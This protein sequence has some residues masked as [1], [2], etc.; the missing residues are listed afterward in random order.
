M[1]NQPGQGVRKEEVGKGG[2]GGRVGK[3]GKEREKGER[4]VKPEG[5]FLLC[6]ACRGGSRMGPW[7]GRREAETW[8]RNVCAERGP[9]E[10]EKST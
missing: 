7:R 8:G 9:R 1:P 4:E 3:R 10:A 5:F 2:Q 6:A